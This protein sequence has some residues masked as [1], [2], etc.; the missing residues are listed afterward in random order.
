MHGTYASHGAA[1]GSPQ[2]NAIVSSQQ[3]AR[4][5]YPSN[6]VVVR[7]TTI[8]T[9]AVATTT[10]NYPVPGQIVHSAA[11]TSV[12]K[13]PAAP[14]LKTPAAPVVPPA[15][16]TR[17]L[18]RFAH[19]GDSDSDTDFVETDLQPLGTLLATL[20]LSSPSKIASTRH[21]VMK[22]TT[23]E[24]PAIEN[25]DDTSALQ[26]PSETSPKQEPNQDL[27]LD[28]SPT[29][30]PTD[31]QIEKVET[32]RAVQTENDV[33]TDSFAS[34]DEVADT[35]EPADEIFL[36]ID[37]PTPLVDEM[38]EPA[39]ELTQTNTEVEAASTTNIE[40]DAELVTIDQPAVDEPTVEL[41]P[42]DEPTTSVVEN[43]ENDASDSNESNGLQ[44]VLVRK[45]V[46]PTE[47]RR[48]DADEKQE[49]STQETTSA[50]QHRARLVL[51]VPESADVFLMNQKMATLGK[52]RLFNVPVNDPTKDHTYSIRVVTENGIVVESTQLIRAGQRLEL[53]FNDQTGT[54]AL[55]PTSP[56]K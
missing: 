25:D 31:R 51:H 4:A 47:E 39:T 9:P 11:A 33:Q 41:S 44:S 26:L 17:V 55:Q 16:K 30:I 19:D 34:V 24:V 54:L 29:L 13:I 46:Q 38:L 28:E 5:Y 10:N 49:T 56:M 14:Q 45:S 23:L 37:D 53:T 20:D 1:G 27:L 48:Q 35:L 42:E 50:T 6:R 7:R 18:E 52:T 22:P 8:D 40:S 2:S 43:Q 12:A 32:T 21:R 3:I 36:A 15:P